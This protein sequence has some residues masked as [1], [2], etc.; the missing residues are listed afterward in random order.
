MAQKMSELRDRMSP[1][2]QARSSSHAEAILLEMGL[3]ALRKSRQMTQVALA[4]AL[5]IDQVA[6]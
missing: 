5:K 4:S 3:Q 2:A 1:E 6:V